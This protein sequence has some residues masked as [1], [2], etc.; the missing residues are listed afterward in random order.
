MGTRR[1][2]G[3][4]G[5]EIRGDVICTH[6]HAMHVS[7]WFKIRNKDKKGY[8]YYIYIFCIFLYFEFCGEN[9]EFPKFS[10]LFYVLAIDSRQE[11]KAKEWFDKETWICV[12]LECIVR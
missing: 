3:G 9:V 6:I 2:G 5:E 1:T 11:L 4:E 8:F 10:S 7:L 12:F